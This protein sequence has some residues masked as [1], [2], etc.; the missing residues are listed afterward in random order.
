MFSR[1]E[2][3]GPKGV[4]L[5]SVHPFFMAVDEKS[6]RCFGVL[7]FNS[8][9]QEYGLLPPHSIS[10]RTTGGELE[11]YIMEE[12]TPERLT[13]AYHALIGLPYMPPYECLC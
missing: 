6:G 7:I 5:Y 9:A 1:D 13:Q 3:P 11:F 8:N 12:E 2:A 4:N 10:Y